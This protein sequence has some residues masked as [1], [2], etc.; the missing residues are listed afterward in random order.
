DR[1]RVGGMARVA[2]VLRQ[3]EAENP[4]TI[5]VIAGD[6]VSPSLIG[7]LSRTVDG[8]TERVA[9]AQM[10]EVLNAVGLDYATFGNHEFDISEAALQARLDESAF[11]YV[12][13]NVRHRS[14]GGEGP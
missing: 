12:S 7:S 14:G 11:A 2:T 8:R 13:A 10:V 9:G 6:F 4:N 5:A 3:L 1:G